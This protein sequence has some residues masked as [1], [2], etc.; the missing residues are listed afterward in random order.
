MGPQDRFQTVEGLEETCHA[1]RS[2]SRQFRSGNTTD[3]YSGYD[4]FGDLSG[5]DPFGDLSGYDPSGPDVY[6][7][8]RLRVH[9]F[10]APIKPEVSGRVLHQQVH[11]WHEWTD[12]S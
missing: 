9:R 10:C 3:G 1:R 11:R 7:T 6:L 12:P 8:G 2:A 5:Y 4:P